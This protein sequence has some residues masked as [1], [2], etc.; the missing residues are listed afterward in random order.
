MNKFFYHV[1]IE[2]LLVILKWRYLII[3]AVFL[4]C[5]SGLL[6]SR[7]LN[8]KFKSKSVI[9]SLSANNDDLYQF[10]RFNNNAIARALGSKLFGIA[11][12]NEDV[13]FG[14]LNSSNFKAII[15]K[16]YSLTQYYKVSN[17]EEAISK[18]ENDFTYSPNEFGMVEI[19][20]LHNDRLLSSKIL[21]F[22]IDKLDSIFSKYQIGIVKSSRI[23]LEKK[24]RSNFVELLVAEDS[25]AKFQ[26]K[27][28]I[29]DLPFQL[30]LSLGVLSDLESKILKSEI[31]NAMIKTNYGYDSYN[32]YLSNKR[33][34]FLKNKLVEH[35]RD[36]EYIIGNQ[37]LFS[38]KVHI[39]FNSLKRFF[40]LKEKIYKSLLPMY[41]VFKLRENMDIPTIL[42]VDKALPP[43]A[44]EHPREEFIFISSFCISLFSSLIF[45]FRGNRILI[46]A[47]QTN[48]VDS[49]EFKFFDKLRKIFRV[50]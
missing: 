20:L 11:K 24:V 47:D 40:S 17:L 36:N 37:Y 5:L 30:K 2:N 13:I 33:L 31:D 9:V 10:S 43:F 4:S 28:G 7:N 22:A 8:H 16:E 32:Y 15:I 35:S 18:F 12:T 21:N 49:F 45:V 26:V 1:I 6:I 39:K 48:L 29:Y 46:N 50:I 3:T 14:I 23:F 44:H 19:S 34:F 42:V 38:P 41:E 25:L 27:Y